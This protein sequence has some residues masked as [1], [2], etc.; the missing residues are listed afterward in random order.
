MMKDKV[1]ILIVNYGNYN[2][3]IECLNSLMTISYVNKH[4]ILVD[5]KSPNDSLYHLRLFQ[6]NNWNNQFGELTILEAENNN[7]FSAGNNIG[8]N[9]FLQKNDSEYILLL[10]NDTTVTTSFL[11]PLVEEAKYNNSN[12]I[13]TGSIRY[14][15]NKNR[16]WYNG[17]GINKLFSYSYHNTLNNHLKRQNIDFASG[18]LMLIS[19]KCLNEIGLL[20]ETF[21]MYYED[22]DYCTRVIKSN[23][24]IVI[25]RDSL[26]YHKVGASNDKALSKFSAYWLAKNRIRYIIENN[27]LPFIL[28]PLFFIFIS[29][30][31]IYPIRY[32]KGNNEII[33]AQ[34]KG[35]KD[36]FS[37]VLSKK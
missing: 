5:N 4:I 15:R 3:T 36:G 37:H 31:A 13:V 14:Y 1:Y 27:N 35:F 12:Y 19:K 29:R 26:I 18:C 17:G 30:M 6:Q 32:L 21:F 33:L 25:R 24:K 20:D 7:G 2:D 9:Y 34:V 10:N 22:L 16:F 28:I 11:E 8:F 23:M